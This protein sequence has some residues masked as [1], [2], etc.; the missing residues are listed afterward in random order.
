M[1]AIAAPDDN[2]FGVELRL[3]DSDQV[4]LL[5]HL[6]ALP[7]PT[8]ERQR[9]SALEIEANRASEIRS[10]LLLVRRPLTPGGVR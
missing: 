3:N 2:R 7:S 4:A 1:T 8:S 10:R 6:F 9:W 5:E